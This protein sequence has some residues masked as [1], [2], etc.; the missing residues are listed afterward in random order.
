MTLRRRLD[1][2][3]A[4]SPVKV[5]YEHTA[6]SLEARRAGLLGLV[7]SLRDRAGERTGT[8]TSLPL[9]AR[10]T[11][12]LGLIESMRERLASGGT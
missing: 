4:E 11:G 3:E 5:Q 10:R 12:L 9:D 6:L 7:A 8:E 2:L 1:R